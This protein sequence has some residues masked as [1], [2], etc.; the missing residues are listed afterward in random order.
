MG[1]WPISW[2]VMYTLLFHSLEYGKAPVLSWS[3]IT[4]LPHIFLS[5]FLYI[6]LFYF[7]LMSPPETS[8]ARVS[9][10]P[11][12]PVQRWIMTLHAKQLLSLT[13][14]FGSDRINWLKE[15]L[16]SF[17]GAS[18]IAHIGDQSRLHQS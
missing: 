10:G 5:K 16:D 7:T 13:W 8:F 14:E 18:E 4:F 15:E 6:K 11:G 1:D 17:L 3:S 12:I 2:P 9:N